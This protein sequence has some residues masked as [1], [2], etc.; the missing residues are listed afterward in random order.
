MSRSAHFAAYAG[1]F[2]KAFVSDE[3]SLLEP[4]FTEEAIYEVALDP[5]MGGRFEGRAAILAYF[6][7]ILD[8]FDRRFESREIARLEGPK[9]DGESVWVHGRATY[10]AK[11]VPDFVLELE[12]T[13]YFEGDRIRRLEDRYGPAMKRR[14]ATYLEKHGEKL[15][16]SIGG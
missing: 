14:I 8:R 13:V 4:F 5:P 9:E 1:A 15:G 10:R 6:K 7:E 3:W 16:I 11:G 2:E 12:E